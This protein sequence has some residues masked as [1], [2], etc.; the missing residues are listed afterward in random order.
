ML[1]DEPTVAC[2][3]DSL[4]MLLWRIYSAESGAEL[5]DVLRDLNRVEDNDKAR[6]SKLKLPSLFAT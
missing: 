4:Y 2:V 1:I 3:A 5:I 6:E